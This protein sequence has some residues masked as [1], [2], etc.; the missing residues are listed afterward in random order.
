M[1]YPIL[2]QALK[3]DSYINYQFVGWGEGVEFG[4]QIPEVVFHV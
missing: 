1:L 4:K 2:L 3:K